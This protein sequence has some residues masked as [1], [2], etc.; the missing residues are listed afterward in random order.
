MAMLTGQLWL[1]GWVGAPRLFLRP[2][3]PA[4]QEQ[5]RPL[6]TRLPPAL[7]APSRISRFPVMQDIQSPFD[8]G[9]DAA[10]DEAAEKLG[11][12]LE[13]P[14]PL[15]FE[16]VELVLDDV[17]PYLQNDGG[18]VA[19][20]EIDGTDV[21]L[22]LQGAC[23]GC[24][25]SSMTMTMGIERRLKEIIPEVGQV[26]QTMPDAEQFSEESVSEIL[27][28]IRPFLKMAGTTIEL[29]WLEESPTQPK[30][31]LRMNG[32]ASVMTAV[33]T[34]IVARLQRKFKSPGMKVEWTTDS[35]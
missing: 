5:L 12:V 2:P 14:L 7:F 19:I 24:P 20:K 32:K 31:A 3:L 27:E 26:F 23:E 11:G 21:Y 13:G 16:N 9:V 10:A 18:D 25:S 8:T 15:T 29:A 17:R 28:E 33:K 22:T 30:V 35:D 6:R 4:H 1:A 34:E